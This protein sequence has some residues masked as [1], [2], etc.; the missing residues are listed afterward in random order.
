[1]AEDCGEETQAM[2]LHRTKSTTQRISLA[3]GKGKMD[4]WGERTQ[5]MFLHRTKSTTQHISLAPGKVKD[6]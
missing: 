2:F 4:D 5:A 3:P 6:R 1:M